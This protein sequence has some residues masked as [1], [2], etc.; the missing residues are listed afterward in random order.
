MASAPALPSAPLPLA[1]TMGDPAGIAPEI[2]LK[3]Y[4][5]A[6]Q[7]HAAPFVVFANADALRATARALGIDCRVEVVTF[8]SDA[9]LVFQQALPVIDIPL[10]APAI[11]GS[12]DSRNGD[13]VIQAITAAVDAARFGSIAA[14]VTNPIAKSVL[15][16]AGFKHPGHTEFLGALARARW[17]TARISE[18]VM[19]LAS[20]ALK[21]VPLTIH[22]P[23]AS[24]PRAITPELIIVTAHTLNAALISDFGLQHPRIAIAGLNPHA[25]EDGTIGR[26]DIDVIAPAISQLRAQGLTVTGP[27]SADTLF[28]AAARGTYDAAICM[29]H[30]QALIPIKTLSFDTGVNV[31]LGL[32]FIRTSPDHGTAFDIAGRGIAS[33]ASLIEALKLARTMAL[34]RDAAVVCA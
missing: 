3:A 6:I 2:T 18:P 14:I 33:P 20:E 12:P 34:R 25:G 23:L 22:I 15:Y 29:Y 24:V 27:H 11:A 5:L 4:Q 10:S 28:H 21:V 30:D 26:E 32:P 13:A 1:L 31:T 7:D 19:L 8:P 17:D 9:A 16:Q